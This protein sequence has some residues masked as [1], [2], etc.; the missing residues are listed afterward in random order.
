MNSNTA[1]EVMEKAKQ[2]S[3]GWFLTGGTEQAAKMP[4]ISHISQLKNQAANTMLRSSSDLDY[5]L[6]LPG[7]D[8][9]IKS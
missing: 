8:E 1:A 6:G 3:Q 4:V 2:G 9:M 7:D 5:I